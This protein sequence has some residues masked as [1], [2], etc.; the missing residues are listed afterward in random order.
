MENT[1]L[2]YIIHGY[3]QR[4]H[5]RTVSELARALKVPQA[6]AWNLWNGNVPPRSIALRRK[7]FEATGQKVFEGSLTAENKEYLLAT[8]EPAPGLHDR[9]SRTAH[10]LLAL[11]I[12]LQELITAGDSVLRDKLRQDLAAATSD[13]DAIGTITTAMRALQS[14]RTL[15]TLRAE[16]QLRKL[17]GGINAS[18]HS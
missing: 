15:E 10:L 8:Y 12:D 6:T 13:P 1:Y 7:L 4:N 17:E 9:A 3:C 2:K 18:S 5:L 14:E 11:R 16:G